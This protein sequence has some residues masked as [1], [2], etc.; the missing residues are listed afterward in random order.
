MNLLTHVELN[1]QRFDEVV[2][3]LGEAFHIKCPHD[4]DGSLGAHTKRAHSTT[5]MLTYLSWQSSR[6]VRGRTG[7]RISSSAYRYL[8]PPGRGLDWGVNS[9]CPDSRLSYPPT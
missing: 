9:A 1:Q 7:V 8:S 3:A 6:L 5:K 2:I 4:L